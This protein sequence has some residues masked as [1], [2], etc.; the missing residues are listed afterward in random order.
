MLKVKASVRPSKIGG[1]GIFAD[2]RIPKG[3]ITWKF[4]PRFDLIF[5]PEEVKKMP[6]EEQ[7]LI[8]KY[9]FLSIK[10]GKYIYP[11]DD[12]RFMN[13]SS[14]NNNEDLI[15]VEGE[16]E[17]IGVA[18]RDIEAGEEI[19]VNYRAIDSRDESSNEDYLKS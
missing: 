11:I 3:T 8:Y 15:T 12:S 1:N 19:L 13:H 2:E 10:T 9:A 17:D 6:Q 7:E 18:N 5:D 16:L 4:H 14:V